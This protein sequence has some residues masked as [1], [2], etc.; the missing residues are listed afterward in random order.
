MGLAFGWSWSE[1]SKSQGAGQKFPTSRKGGEK[2]G[3]PVRVCVA[4]RNAI[5]L[6]SPPNELRLADYR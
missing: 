3:T 1:W 6:S 2:W 5:K 4:Y